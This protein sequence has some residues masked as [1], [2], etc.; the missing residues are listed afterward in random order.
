[1]AA[2]LFGGLTGFLTLGFR[3]SNTVRKESMIEYEKNA[4]KRKE[5]E[6]KYQKAKVKAKQAKYK[7]KQAKSNNKIPHVQDMKREL[8]F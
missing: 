3:A 6:E 8:K 7:A 2:S 1:M 4:P 5:K